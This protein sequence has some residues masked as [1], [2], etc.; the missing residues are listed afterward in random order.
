MSVLTQKELDFIHSLIPD[1]YELLTALGKIPAPSH[2][3]DKRAQFCLEYMKSL[4]AESVFIDA[5]KNVVCEI[6]CEGKDQVVIFSAHTDVVFPD[7]DALPMKIEG[8]KIFAPGIGDD[9]GNLINLLMGLKYLLTFPGT[10]PY[11]IVIVANSCEEGLGNLDGTRQIMKTY[12]GRI[13][14]FISFDGY[15][16]QCC[17][18]AV[19]S[20]RY[21]ITIKTEGGHS[22]ANFGNTSAIK[23]AADVIEK[24]YSQ[25]VPTTSKT[26]YNVG[27]IEGGT[28]VNTIAEKAVLLYEFRSETQDC[29]EIM[30]KQLN[31]IIDE[32]KT[33]GKDITLKTLGIRPGNRPIPP[34]G[35]DAFT[36]RNIEILLRYLDAPLDRSPYSTDSNLPLSLGIP[37]NTIGTVHGAGAHTYGEWIYFPFQETGMKIVISLLKKYWTI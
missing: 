15:A 5:A 22:Y 29:L 16:P 30:A 13:K 14:E 28:T 1:N 24:L 4:G 3:E 2:Q 6:G 19:G 34:K 37:A 25:K 10:C 18:R 27:C 21:Q 36:D 26:S 33:A 20:H 12:E 9:T 8:D 11:G 7:R 35:L 31:E 23:V 32:F 17:S